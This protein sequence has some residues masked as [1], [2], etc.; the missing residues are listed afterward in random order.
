[1]GFGFRKGPE[2]GHQSSAS[3]EL[4]FAKTMKELGHESEQM[5]LIEL[6]ER[7]EQIKT[8]LMDR[9]KKNV[10][11]RSEEEL[12]KLQQETVD[13]HGILAKIEML[14]LYDDLAIW[15][16]DMLQQGLL[17]EPE[18][19]FFIDQ[20]QKSQGRDNF[21]TLTLLTTLAEFD[22]YLREKIINNSAEEK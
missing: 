10:G 11:D 19:K 15:I 2:Q 3:E 4:A 9:Y 21:T 14:D 22:L 16:N 13:K 17:T 7:F 6:K 12:L 5:P 1:M 8:D 18:A 20:L